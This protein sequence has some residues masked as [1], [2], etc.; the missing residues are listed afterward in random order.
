[1]LIGV[2]CDRG[3]QGVKGF[4]PTGLVKAFEHPAGETT[5]EL[6]G[7]IGGGS[8]SHRFVKTLEGDTGEAGVAE[9]GCHSIRVC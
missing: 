9:D 3:P 4:I 2:V 5:D 6:E 1:M 7:I 8:E